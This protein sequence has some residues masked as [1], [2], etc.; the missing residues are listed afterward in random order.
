MYFFI[1]PLSLESRLDCGVTSRDIVVRATRMA[2]NWKNE[3]RLMLSSPHTL[4]ESDKSKVW[5]ED[6]FQML[7]LEYNDFRHWVDLLIV[8]SIFV[9][10]LIFASQCVSESSYRSNLV[11]SCLGTSVNVWSRTAGCKSLTIS[12]NSK[13]WQNWCI[14]S[15]PKI[16]QRV[17]ALNTLLLSKML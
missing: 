9:F 4:Y 14:S 12:S 7:Y 8:H 17:V 5:K 11:L 1:I 10:W 15:W 3:L 6:D 13:C 2:G 16:W